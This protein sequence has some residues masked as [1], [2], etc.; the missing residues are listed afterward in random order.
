MSEE[1]KEKIRKAN[2]GK[3]RKTPVWN[4]G[5]KYEELFGEKKAEILKKNISIMKKGSKMSRETKKK[6]RKNH[7][8]KNGYL[9]GMKGKKQ[10]K[11]Q[12]EIAKQSS[13]GNKYAKGNKPNK[14][15]FKKGNIPPNYK[16]E[17]ATYSAK[18]IWIKTRKCSAKEYKCEICKTK[19]AQ[20]WSNKNHKYKRILKDWQ[21]VC[22]KC[23]NRYDI[24]NNNKFAGQKINFKSYTLT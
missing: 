3:K 1:L 23:H 20:H 9:S 10:S 7:R 13:L 6:M 15:S 4:K 24:K 11:H 17:N 2:T 5:K 14:T 22:S 16:G 12:K 19:Q 18:H 21:A 8:T